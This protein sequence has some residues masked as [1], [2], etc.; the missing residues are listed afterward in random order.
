MSLS[1]PR[2]TVDL[3]WLLLASLFSLYPSLSL[4]LLLHSSI[5]VWMSVF[6]LNIMPFRPLPRLSQPILWAGP[7]FFALSLLSCHSPVLPWCWLRTLAA[8]RKSECHRDVP[9]GRLHVWICRQLHRP[10]PDL[11]VLLV[12]GVSLQQVWP[13]PATRGQPGTLTLHRQHPEGPKVSLHL[14]YYIWVCTL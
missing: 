12:C 10:V 13:R 11:A 14:L 6:S 8:N 9:A 1:C 4:I 3:F 2:V 5:V 7:E